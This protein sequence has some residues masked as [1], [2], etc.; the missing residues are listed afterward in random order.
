MDVPQKHGILLSGGR[1]GWSYTYLSM[2]LVL[3]YFHSPIDNT[4]LA[5]IFIDYSW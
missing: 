1:H 2:T 3:K 4:K 5:T